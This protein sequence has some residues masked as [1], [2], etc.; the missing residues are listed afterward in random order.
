MKGF[1]ITHKGAEDICAG[2]IAE[3]IEIKES[4]IN[5]GESFVTFPIKKY[6]ELFL[7]CYKS[8][9]SI[10][11]SLYLGCVEAHTEKEIIEEIK[12]MEFTLPFEFSTFR[13]E[14]IKGGNYD[15]KSQEIEKK[16]GGEI[17]RKYKNKKVSLTSPELTI[18]IY[19]CGNNCLAGIDFSGFD[20][21]KRDYKLFANKE[22]LKGTIA[23][24]ALRFA[25][26]KKE[27]YLLDVFL[28]DGVIP[29]E[30]A[31]YASNFS[32]NYF[33]KDK[34][35]F[36]KLFRE[37]DF[38]VFFKKIEA[39]SDLS[40]ARIKGV[41]HLL[42]DVKAAQKNAKIAG[43]AKAVNLTKISVD[44]LDIKLKEGEIDKMVSLIPHSEN[45]GK[46][47]NEL[48]YQAEYIL[49]QKGTITLILRD[50]KI[51]KIF[52]DA[53]EKHGFRLKKEKEV[54]TG[55]QKLAFLNF[56]GKEFTGKNH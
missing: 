45:P 32:V 14:A 15:F 17:L 44:W 2:E 18:I 31:A 43:V 55:Q 28:G 40:K 56:T 50:E 6:E 23:Y 27:D 25:G 22:S 5:I 30:A 51:R 13:V 54:R 9:S 19:L 37:Y 3:I 46:M 26:Y 52:V 12:K 7:L 39:Q 47:L 8:Q 38:E 34:F 20:L 36:L 1:A 35:A 24:S 33:R 11:I 16:I 41:S 48:F 42:R 10:N 49:S 53:A 29:I 21:S 4:E